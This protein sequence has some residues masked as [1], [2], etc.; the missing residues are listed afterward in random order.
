MTE[1]RRI[2]DFIAYKRSVEAKYPVLTSS[3]KIIAVDGVDGSGKTTLSCKICSILSNTFGKDGILL[4][5]AT[6]L[7]GSSNQVRLNSI[8]KSRDDFHGDYRLDLV[9]TA[10]VNRAYGDLIYP[11]IEA[12]KIVVVDRSEVD[13]LRYAIERKDEI[14]LSKRA[15]FIADGTLTHRLWAGNRVFLKLTADD[16]WANLSERGVN[17]SYDPRSLEEVR[18]RIE[19][20]DEAE[21]AILRISASG[22][23]NVIAIPNTRVEDLIEREKYLSD[24]AKQIVENLVID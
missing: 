23:V 7:Q 5:S 18:R 12:G 17:S 21:A 6:N 9:Y 10:G 16:I 22:K 19:A 15:A 8:S 14:S 13:L 1:N 11:A 4:V 2:S 20:Q 3:P 24:I